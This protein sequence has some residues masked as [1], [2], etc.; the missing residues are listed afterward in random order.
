VVQ[1][2]TPGA[3]DPAWK[4]PRREDGVRKGDLQ[5]ITHRDPDPVFTRLF[6][7]KPLPVPPGARIRITPVRPKILFEDLDGPGREAPSGET[8]P[9]VFPDPLVICGEEVFKGSHFAPSG[10]ARDG[11]FH[12]VRIV[13]GPRNGEGQVNGVPVALYDRLELVLHACRDIGRRKRKP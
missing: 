10:L 7:K 2:G 13:I 11:P 8:D 6:K 4:R 12:D 5:K 3:P 1:K 9:T